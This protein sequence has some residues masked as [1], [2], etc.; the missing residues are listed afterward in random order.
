M[1]YVRCL[2]DWELLHNCLSANLVLCITGLL[3]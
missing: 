1:S 3:D 2:K